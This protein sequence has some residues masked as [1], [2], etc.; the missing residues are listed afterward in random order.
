MQ[1]NN[2]NILVVLFSLIVVILAKEIKLSDDV[3]E[4]VPL[5]T[6][7]K[8]LSE[9][10]LLHK[11]YKAPLELTFEIGLKD[12]YQNS[13]KTLRQ[14][15]SNAA[16]SN[17]PNLLIKRPYNIDDLTLIKFSADG[18]EV[19]LVMSNRDLYIIGFV[20]RNKFYR[21]SDPP[22]K[23]IKVGNMVVIDLKTNSDYGS[24][25]GKAGFT[26]VDEVGNM[27]ITLIN[28]KSYFLELTKL[29][30][31]PSLQQQKQVALAMLRFLIFTAEASRFRNIEQDIAQSLYSKPG[32]YRL[33]GVGRDETT[34][35]RKFSDYGVRLQ[36]NKTSTET[37][38]IGYTIQTDKGSLSRVDRNNLSSVLAL[39]LNNANL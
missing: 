20:S 32:T 38:N 22:F 17:V 25:A 2:I 14:L 27:E 30:G 6:D 5:E 16:W 11:N 36:K 28:L 24:L 13:I 9:I 21:F 4:I 8:P 26:S 34:D 35:W 23:N 1:Q 39:A 7:D 10:V 29:D 15:L 37:Y 33:G 31:D 18:K 12:K 3:A 19:Q